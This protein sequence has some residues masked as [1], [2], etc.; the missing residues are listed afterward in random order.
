MQQ[1]DEPYLD[2]IGDESLPQLKHLQHGGSGVVGDGVALQHVLGHHHLPGQPALV[3]RRVQR[4]EVRQV[5]RLTAAKTWNHNTAVTRTQ[6]I[7]VLV[8]FFFF[9]HQLGLW[10]ITK[11]IRFCCIWE[12]VKLCLK[13]W[14]MF[15]VFLQMAFTCQGHEHYDVYS[16]CNIK[17]VLI[18][19]CKRGIV[20][21]WEKLSHSSTIQGQ[22]CLTVESKAMFYPLCNSAS[23]TCWNQNYFTCW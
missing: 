6:K 16:L 3:E 19:S 15:S 8:I 18:S 12:V 17:C 13:D 23:Y 1:E 14:C 2:V 10:R 5:T 7:L 11:L 4:Q 21:K 20:T 9:I 22:H